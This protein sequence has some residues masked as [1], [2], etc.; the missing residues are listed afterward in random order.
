ML[1]FTI[2]MRTFRITLFILLLSALASIA[3]ADPL[4][5]SLLKRFVDI[6]ELLSNRN[7]EVQECSLHYK[8]K[9]KHENHLGACLYRYWNLH[10]SN[11]GQKAQ[12]F[13]RV[14][15]PFQP[16][17]S[18]DISLELEWNGAREE[19]KKNFLKNTLKM[20]SDFA[21]PG[22]GVTF[23]TAKRM[24]KSLR[25]LEFKLKPIDP[26]PLEYLFSEEKMI[27]FTAGLLLE[28]S[29]ENIRPSIHQIMISKRP[30]D[31]KPLK[32]NFKDKIDIEIAVENGLEIQSEMIIDYSL[33]LKSGIKLNELDGRIK[34]TNT[35]S[36]AFH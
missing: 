16:S 22:A 13:V 17:S 7:I 8:D 24:Y 28:D 3:W 10:L 11:K 2:G 25:H 15:L 30:R 36:S 19:E 9:V 18:P 5:H 14:R 29:A 6:D 12:V 31:T 21:V 20:L 33:S 32:G 27:Y 35:E 23:T 26:V 34:L 1:I 4:G